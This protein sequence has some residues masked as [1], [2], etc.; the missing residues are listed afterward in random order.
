MGA[1][2]LVEQRRCQLA[3]LHK[4]IADALEV[5]KY[6]F[7]FCKIEDGCME[8]KFFIPDF[9]YSLVFPLTNQ[10]CHS[11]VEIGIIKMAW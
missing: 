10:Q 4:A 9:L 8:L 11:L 1:E 2:L 3:L 6:Q 7:Y 5:P